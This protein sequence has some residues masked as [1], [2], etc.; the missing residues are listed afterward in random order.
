MG[1][2]LLIIVYSFTFNV[3]AVSVGNEFLSDVI[4]TVVLLPGNVPN[5][6]QFLL[7]NEA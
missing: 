6:C 7:V 3:V 5:L 1:R 2:L 4:V